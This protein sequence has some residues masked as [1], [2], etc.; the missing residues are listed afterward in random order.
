MPITLL[1]TQRQRAATR[2]GVF[3]VGAL[4][5][6]IGLATEEAVVLALVGLVVAVCVPRWLLLGGSIVLQ[7][8]AVGG[9]AV[10][11][12]LTYTDLLLL[13]WVFRQAVILLRS[14]QTHPP[15]VA[16][17]LLGL[18]IWGTLVTLYSGQTLTPWAR[19]ATYGAIGVLLACDPSD[20]RRIYSVITVGAVARLGLALP[21][22]VRGE[23][24]NDDNVG[25]PHQFAMF[26]VAGGLPLL[27]LDNQPRWRRV[28]GWLLLAAAFLTYRRAVWA[29]LLVL[30]VAI[31][32]RTLSFNRLVTL[33]V[34]MAI[35][36]LA[37]FG[38]IT[39][40]FELNPGSY[41]IRQESIERGIRSGLD[42]PITGVGWAGPLVTPVTSDAGLTVESTAT[43]QNLF[44]GLLAALGLVGLGLGCVYLYTSMRLAE[45]QNPVAFLFIAGFIALSLSGMTW[46]ANSLMTMVFFVYAGTASAPLDASLPRIR[47]RRSLRV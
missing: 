36:G 24:L 4:G 32:Q 5:L 39:R 23:H 8:F 42:R 28:L 38:T 12:P 25:D 22:A 3:V 14:H 9:P 30:V 6:G 21:F 29:A 19:V 27:L 41:A 15:R 44:I 1:E 7:A 11:E 34:A 40:R 17:V 18:L 20:V 47:V 16:Q 2:W 46:F 26:M 37:A 45:Q 33:I 13:L 35:L 43:A 10:V 31:W